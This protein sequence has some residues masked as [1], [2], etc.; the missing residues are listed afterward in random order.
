MIIKGFKKG[1]EVGIEKI[2]IGIEE[3]ID[4]VIEDLIKIEIGDIAVVIEIENIKVNVIVNV[5]EKN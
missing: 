3:I 4:I 5:N 2:G 1:Q